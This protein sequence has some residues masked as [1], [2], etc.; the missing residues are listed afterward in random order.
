V[1]MA[2]AIHIW[3]SRKLPGTVIPPDAAQYPEEPPE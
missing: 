2:Q 1:D 3:T